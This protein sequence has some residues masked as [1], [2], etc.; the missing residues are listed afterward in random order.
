MSW[1]IDETTDVQICTTCGEWP[2]RCRCDEARMSASAPEQERRICPDCRGTT[3]NLLDPND[4]GTCPSCFG[5][6]LR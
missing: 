6:Y 5:G 2:L 3:L 4:G 1:E